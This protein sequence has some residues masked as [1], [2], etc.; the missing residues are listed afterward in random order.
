LDV[1]NATQAGAL[2]VVEQIR[3]DDLGRPTPCS[4]W[5]VR[6]CL[7]KLVASTRFSTIAVAEGRRD[8]TLDLTAPPDLVGDDPVGSYRTAAADCYSA[9]SDSAAW[10]RTVPTALVG[11]DVTGEQ[12]IHIRIFDTTVIT[13]DLARA[14]GVDHGIGQSQAD[15]AHEMAQIV[16]PIVI[17]ATDHQR[18]R[19]PTGSPPADTIGRLIAATGRDPGWTAP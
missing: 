2:A 10:Q 13:W 16:I 6:T 19:S 8:T 12:M 1:L 18:F 9:L 7:N 14:I 17:R 15:Y 5:N 4:D 11:L 3:P